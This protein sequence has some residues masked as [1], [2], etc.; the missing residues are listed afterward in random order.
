MNSLSICSETINNLKKNQQ[1]TQKELKD[2]KD[3]NS[4]QL[5]KIQDYEKTIQRR[6]LNETSIADKT[7]EITALKNQ[8]ESNTYKLEQQLKQKKILE[9]TTI[10][11]NK[12]ITRLNDENTVLKRDVSSLSNEIVRMHTALTLN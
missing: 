7:I 5:K 11:L 12:T 9:D 6:S 3:Q 2:L 1:D 10:T 4:A 8:L